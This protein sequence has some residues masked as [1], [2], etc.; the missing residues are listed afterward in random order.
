MELLF[1][2][3]LATAYLTFS[4]RMDFNHKGP[5]LFKSFVRD[6]SGSEIRPVGVFDWI[7]RPFG[8]YIVIQE[9][10]LAIWQVRVRPGWSAWYCPFCLSFW[11]QLPLYV[12]DLTVTHSLN[13]EQYPFYLLAVPLLA[14]FINVFIETVLKEEL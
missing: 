11:V 2:F 7:R 10:D 6:V 1:W 9:G 8:V 3:V 4:F 14:G 5:G 12:Y 13:L